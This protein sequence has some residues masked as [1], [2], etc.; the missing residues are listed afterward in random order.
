MWGPRCLSEGLCDERQGTTDGH[1]WTRMDTDGKW[2]LAVVT[3]IGEERPRWVGACE[4]RDVDVMD[5]VRD[6]M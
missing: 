2:A 1:G 5:C 6:R 4:V 3:R